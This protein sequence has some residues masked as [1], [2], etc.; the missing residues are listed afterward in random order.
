M[1]CRI[2]TNLIVYRMIANI[3][4]QWKIADC[5]ENCITVTEFGKYV[6]ENSK[7]YYYKNGSWV[8]WKWDF[9]TQNLI[10]YHYRL[11]EPNL[12]SCSSSKCWSSGEI[13]EIRNF[14]MQPWKF[15]G[16]PRVHDQPAWTVLRVSPP[17][18]LYSAWPHFCHLV[19]PY[20]EGMQ[21]CPFLSF[22]T[23]NK[24]FPQTNLSPLSPFASDLTCQ[25]ILLWE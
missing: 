15:F 2:G 25:I 18:Y 13:M 9:K 7:E 24:Q 16:W 3:T 5:I 17:W 6:R 14:W 20:A 12:D 23:K 8:T 1:K 19:R 11:E 4:S 10:L 22:Q 21:F